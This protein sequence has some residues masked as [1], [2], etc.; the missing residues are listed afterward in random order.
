MAVLGTIIIILKNFLKL[1]FLIYSKYLSSLLSEDLK[2]RTTILD[3]DE[4]AYSSSF[5]YP[6][7]S[8]IKLKLSRNFMDIYT[9]KLFYY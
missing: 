3:P 9:F 8:W 2:G 1:I 4:Y 5:K 6:M 7:L